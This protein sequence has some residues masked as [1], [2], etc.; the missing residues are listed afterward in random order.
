MEALKRNPDIVDA[1]SEARGF[2]ATLVQE[3]I[4]YRGVEDERDNLQSKLVH[5]TQQYTVNEI[6]RNFCRPV[7]PF[8]AKQYYSATGVRARR[9]SLLTLWTVEIACRR[10]TPPRNAC[11]LSPRTL[12]ADL[13]S[14]DDGKNWK[15]LMEDRSLIGISFRTILK[16]ILK[17]ATPKHPSIATRLVPHRGGYKFLARGIKYTMRNYVLHELSLQINSAVGGFRKEGDKQKLLGY[18]ELLRRNDLVFYPWYYDPD[19]GGMQECVFWAEGF[20]MDKRQ[21][22]AVKDR[23][24]R[25]IAEKDPKVFALVADVDPR[26]GNYRFEFRCTPLQGIRYGVQRYPQPTPGMDESDWIR[27]TLPDYDLEE[28]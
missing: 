15:A 23:I 7:L 13:E 27:E 22:A 10:K 1:S 2:V 16:G 9:P 19:V 4:A 24:K 25:Q 6:A 3:G 14:E 18:Y 11:L 17:E 12:S 5:D 21:Y 28:D 26:D 8:Y 20:L